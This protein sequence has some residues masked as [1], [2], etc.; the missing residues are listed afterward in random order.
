VTWALDFLTDDLKTQA[1]WWLIRVMVLGEPAKAEQLLATLEN[2]SL[3]PC[4]T[5]PLG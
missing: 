1:Y 5:C 4:F 3:V 2:L